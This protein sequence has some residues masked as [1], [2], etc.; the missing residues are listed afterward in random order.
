[1]YWLS[2][3]R[4]EAKELGAGGDVVCGRSREAQRV[5]PLMPQR[6]RDHRLVAAILQAGQRGMPGIDDD[7]AQPV[8]P[9]PDR[10][11]EIR[12]EAIGEAWMAGRDQQLVDVVAQRTIDHAAL[13]GRA[14]RR[15]AAAAAQAAGD[16]EDLAR[17]P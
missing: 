13:L 5:T 1:M 6:P 3:R 15:A 8:D 2:S 11:I 4:C 14:A 16:R 10:A 9:R 7:Q 17:R 12:A